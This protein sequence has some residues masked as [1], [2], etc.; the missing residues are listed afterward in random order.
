MGPEGAVNIIFKN[1]SPEERKVKV[2][3]YRDNFASPFKAAEVGYIDEIIYPR[4]TRKKLIQALEMTAN[5]SESNPPKK[6]G[7]I[8]L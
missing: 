4:N 6:H 8:P 3:E 1:L 2:Q 7:N 5:K